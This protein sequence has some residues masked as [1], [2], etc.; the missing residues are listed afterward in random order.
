M[1]QE[2][3]QPTNYAF[4]IVKRF[5]PFL[6]E[7]MRKDKSIYKEIEQ[8]G[9]LIYYENQNSSISKYNNALQREIY[10]FCKGIGFHRSKDN[11]WISREFNK[12]ETENNICDNE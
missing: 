5:F 4:Y 2:I 6:F 12:D 10:A 11:R 7:K 9:H 1:K 3:K 8:I